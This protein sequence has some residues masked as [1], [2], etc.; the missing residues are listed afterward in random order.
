MSLTNNYFDRLINNSA[1]KNTAAILGTL[2]T[3]IALT[4][5]ITLL[6][7]FGNV[8]EKIFAG[9]TFFFIFWASLFYWAILADTGK[10]AWSRILIILLPVLAIDTV[11]LLFNLQIK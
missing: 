4:V 10:Q 11:S 7:P 2:I 8:V 9:G 5:C 3:T 1:S 6:W